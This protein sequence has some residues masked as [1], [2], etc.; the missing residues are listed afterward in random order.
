L[1]SFPPLEQTDPRKAEN[2]DDQFRKAT[3]KNTPPGPDGKYILKHMTGNEFA[4]FSMVNN[5]FQVYE[6]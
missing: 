5:Y 6:E 4:G 3:L 1:L 2:F